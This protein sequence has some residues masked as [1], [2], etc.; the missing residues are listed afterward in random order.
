MAI[1]EIIN[2]THLISEPPIVLYHTILQ[3]DYFF[4]IKKSIILLNKGLGRLKISLHL[5]LYYIIKRPGWNP[6]LL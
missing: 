4:S 3:K 1:L 6:W 5:G 2:L